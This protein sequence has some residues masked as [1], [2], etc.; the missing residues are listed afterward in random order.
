MEGKSTEATPNSTLKDALRA[1][2]GTAKR[3]DEFM[4][5]HIEALKASEDQTIYRTGELL[6]QVK[7]GLVIGYSAPIAIVTI[8]QLLLGNPLNAVV[9]FATTAVSPVAITCAA[10]GAIWMGW[11]A[12]K[13]TEQARILELVHNGLGVSV[14]ALSGVVQFAVELAQRLFGKPQ[15]AVLRE[16]VSSEATAFGKTLAQVTGSAFDAAMD[17]LPRR[18]PQPQGADQDLTEVLWRLNRE[19]LCGILRGTFGRRQPL[20]EMELPE[21]RQLVRES[22]ATAAS[23]SWPWASAPN[24]PQAVSLVARQLKLPSS[25]RVHVRDLERA[26]LFKVVELSLGKL[27]ETQQADLTR[28]IEEELKASGVERRVAFQEVVAFVKTGAVDIGGT[29]GGL[30]FAGPGL[31]GIAGLN[32]LQFVVLKSIIMTSGYFAGGAALLGFGTGGLLLTLAGWAGPIGVG[33]A[34]AFTTYSIAGPAY[35]KLVP[36]VCLIAAKRLELGMQDHPTD[37]GQAPL[38]P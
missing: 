22:F 20:D 28:R 10:V 15:M 29:L 16:M 36:A 30:V 24:Y 1:L 33:L 13:S 18:P 34:V 4:S 37:E 25:S 31:Y 38:N 3:L 11:R 35:R 12:L 27:D 6:A 7:S 8:G 14:K 9:S 21:L 19:E 26:I 2:Y 23:Y 5:D 32:F 17:L